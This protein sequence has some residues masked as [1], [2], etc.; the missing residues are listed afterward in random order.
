LATLCEEW[1]KVDPV[2]NLLFDLYIDLFNKDEISYEKI[3]EVTLNRLDC[4]PMNNESWTTLTSLLTSDEYI[5]GWASAKQ[6]EVFKV[7]ELRE[8]MKILKKRKQF[9]EN[10]HFSNF[11]FNK[12]DNTILGN[13][14][15]CCFIL[16][17]PE[18]EF[19]KKCIEYLLKKNLVDR[20]QF[21]ALV[22]LE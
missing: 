7:Q 6:I 18:A 16:V 19:S 13:K 3:I 8:K 4:L 14:C 11:T 2:D 12:I 22:G 10:I 1:S 15:V 20:N 5:E 9:I 17:G 21:Y